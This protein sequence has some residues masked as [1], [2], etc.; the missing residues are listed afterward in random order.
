MEEDKISALEKAMETMPQTVTEVVED[1]FGVKYSKDRRKLVD[2]KAYTDK[3]YEIDDRVEIICDKAFKDCGNLEEIVM[4]KSLK[5]IGREAFSGCGRLSALKL[6][7]SVEEIGMLAFDGCSR[8]CDL[9]IPES[10]RSL[11]DSALN[12]VKY[13]PKNRFH[14]IK[15]FGRHCLMADYEIVAEAL[16]DD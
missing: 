6:P 14:I 10:V 8:L 16:R 11:L 9:E 12:G 15:R 7:D 3:Y 13:S 5:K 1:V 2:A 4:P